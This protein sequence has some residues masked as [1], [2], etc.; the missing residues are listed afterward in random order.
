[1][2]GFVNFSFSS[3]EINSHHR[4]IE[5]LGIHP[6]NDDTDLPS[7]YSMS[8]Y[9]TAATTYAAVSIRNGEK[10]YRGKDGQPVIVLKDF[11]MTVSRGCIYSLLGSSGSGK[12]T[13]LKVM[14]GVHRLDQGDVKVFGEIPGTKE[15][16]IPGS[17]AG[18]MPQE[19]ALYDDF[20]I[21]EMLSYFGKI[22][23]MSASEISE[24]SEFLINLLKL[25]E[26]NRKVGSLSGGQ[27]RRVSFAVALVH[28]PPLLILDEPTVGVD[29]TLR[30]SIWKYLR[31]L[32]TESKTTV[33]ITTHYIEETRQSD[34]IGVM[35]NGKILVEKHPDVLLEQYNQEFLE[36]V[37]LTLCHSDDYADV[38]V[39]N[40]RE[41]SF[42][43]ILHADETEENHNMPIKAQF[44][45]VKTASR[46]K[47][48]STHIQALVMKTA[49]LYLRNFVFL[50][51]SLMFPFSQVLV[52]ALTIGNKPDDPSF[53]VVNYDSMQSNCSFA[54]KFENCSSVGLSCKYLSKLEQNGITL[55]NYPSEEVAYE[56]VARGNVWGY[57]KFSK[58]FS[59][60]Y[61]SMQEYNLFGEGVDDKFSHM[62]H[63]KMDMS[64]R[65]M[66][67]FYQQLMIRVYEEFAS[68]FKEA[69]D[70]NKGV[71]EFPMKIA[72]PIF[73]S[74][75]AD[76]RQFILISTIVMTVYF[77]PMI[78]SSFWFI[79]DKRWGTQGR[80]IVAGV[81]TWEIMFSSY[82]IECPI[83]IFQ[84]VSSFLV[85]VYICDVR[86]S[87]S[88]FLAFALCIIVG[89]CGV[90][91]GFLIATFCSEE[92]QVGIAVM[93]ELSFTI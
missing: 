73:G 26:P 9:K 66:T 75:D 63:V 62:I 16:R 48:A 30:L 29:P 82:V 54:P 58:N 64:S 51:F 80:A 41:E 5:I 90:S 67:Q 1:M 46:F 25:P 20:T 35:R 13:A 89:F 14:V 61:H 4:N 57:M 34:M 88:I 2:A 87:G 86:I 3:E 23:S 52:V 10:S 27:Q 53:G 49:T 83:T 60:Y 11:N 24:R 39:S 19:T 7:R 22:Y 8:D 40:T 37:V 92:I 77:F 74:N 70:H 36:D 31:Q 43:A 65:M 18:Y 6:H 47:T 32:A 21:Q 81:K 69:C 44:S 17:L 91:G 50:L 45:E 33:L 59:S 42:P 72:D 28:N 15:S 56:E 78:S 76:F 93:G 38:G 55:I 85:S 84:I 12:T 68:E 71:G 79:F